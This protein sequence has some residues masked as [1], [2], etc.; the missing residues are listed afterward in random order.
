MAYENSTE[1][2]S[3]SQVE[4]ETVRALVEAY[5]AGKIELEQPDKKT[6][7]QAIRYAPGLLS[8]ACVSESDTHPYTAETVG[9]FL[10]WTKGDKDDKGIFR[11]RTNLFP[12]PPHPS[13]DFLNQKIW[14]GKGIRNAPSFLSGA[15]PSGL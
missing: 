1:Y 13:P 4:Q 11:I 10:G 15:C 2:S 3:S 14:D 7:K 12:T 5:A 6:N 9:E 8:G